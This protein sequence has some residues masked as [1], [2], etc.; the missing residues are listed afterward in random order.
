MGGR[1]IRE[2]TRR[3]R[4]FGQRSQERGR[5]HRRRRNRSR[6]HGGQRRLGPKQNRAPRRWARKTLGRSRLRTRNLRRQGEPPLRGGTPP[7]TPRAPLSIRSDQP[8]I[9]SGSKSRTQGILPGR[10][11]SAQGGL[12]RRTPGWGKVRACLFTRCVKSSPIASRSSLSS[13]ALENIEALQRVIHEASAVSLQQCRREACADFG[14]FEAHDLDRIAGFA[15][16][17]T[18]T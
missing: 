4:K 6:I 1:S 3:K 17:L 13:R 15:A 10:T 18:E 12:D 16:H 2:R 7:S 5:E 9:A 11:D 8:E 14:D